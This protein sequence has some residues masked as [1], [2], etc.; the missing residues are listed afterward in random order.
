MQAIDLLTRIGQAGI[1]LSQDKFIYG[2]LCLGLYPL[3]IYIDAI[4]ASPA[5]VSTT[6][7]LSLF[8]FLH[9][10]TFTINY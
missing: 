4:R 3:P 6:D 5:P 8:G 1:V 10:V 9:Y 7:I 2:F